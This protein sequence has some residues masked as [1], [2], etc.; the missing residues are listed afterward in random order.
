MNKFPRK[1][2]WKLCQRNPKLLDGEIIPEILNKI[3]LRLFHHHCGCNLFRPHGVPRWSWPSMPGEGGCTGTC[4][5]GMGTRDHLG[6]PAQRAA[7][8]SHS[9][10][11]DLHRRLQEGNLLQ[12]RHHT[13]L[14]LSLE[15]VST[16]AGVRLRNLKRRRGFDANIL[17]RKRPALS[18]AERKTKVKEIDRQCTMM[19][20]L[21]TQ[22]LWSELFMLA[23]S[24]VYR[25]AI[26]RIQSQ[27]PGG[28]REIE[29]TMRRWSKKCQRWWPCRCFL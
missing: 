4:P 8:V 1:E 13:K 24:V 12:I 7:Q 29:T 28:W 2:I 11:E 19:V 27:G 16:D 20:I 23:R 22:K 5:P 14:D 9:R 10:G 15:K 26:K 21:T 25:S 3:S 18:N 6:A 17:P